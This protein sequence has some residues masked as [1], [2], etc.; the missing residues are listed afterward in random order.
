MKYD[1]KWGHGFTVGGET[2]AMVLTVRRT[3][4]ADKAGLLRGDFI[5]TVSANYSSGQ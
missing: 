5:L 2:P 1:T 4:P 3:S